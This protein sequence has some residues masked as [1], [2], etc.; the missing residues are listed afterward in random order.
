MPKSALR[1]RAFDSNLCSS[2]SSQPLM[3]SKRVSFVR[4]LSDL[5]ITNSVISLLQLLC[6]A[7]LADKQQQQT[8]LEVALNSQKH[9]EVVERVS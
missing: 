4:L 9:F 7:V 2:S 6:F 5:K 8:Q 3:D 1:N